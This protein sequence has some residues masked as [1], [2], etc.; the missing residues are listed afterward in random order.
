M[1]ARAIRSPLL[2][3]EGGRAREGLIT[4]PSLSCR[5]SPLSITCAHAANTRMRRQL[6]AG[7]LARATGR[8]L[9]PPLVCLFI[10]A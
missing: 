1:A 8:T 6:K 3:G 5:L 2:R 9:T 10:S 4:P 7:D